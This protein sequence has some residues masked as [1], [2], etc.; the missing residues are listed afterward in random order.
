MNVSVIQLW[1]PERLL[2][3]TCEEHIL[4]AGLVLHNHRHCD[5]R[6]QL[7]ANFDDLLQAFQYLDTLDQF[8]S[9]Y[10]ETFD[11]LKLPPLALDPIAEQVKSNSSVL[12]ILTSTIENLSQK[13]TSLGCSLPHLVALLLLCLLEDNLLCQVLQ[14]RFILIFLELL[15]HL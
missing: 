15:N 7:V 5:K 11:P 6:S 8:P 14:H 4:S 2:R 1:K 9:I 12:K 3:D 10:C 13:L